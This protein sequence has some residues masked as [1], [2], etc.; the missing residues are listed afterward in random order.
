MTEAAFRETIKPLLRPNELEAETQ[1]HDRI[2]D[3]LNAPPHIRGQVQDVPALVQQLQRLKTKL[4]QSAPR[5]YLP[6]DADHAVRRLAELEASIKADMPSAEDMRRAPPGAVDRH[7]RWERAH[8][9]E[10]LEWKNIRLRLHATECQGGRF[11]HVKDVANIEMIRPTGFNRSLDDMGALVKHKD[12]HLPPGPITQAVL[13]TDI[14]RALLKQHAPEI[15]DALPLYTNEQRQA[16][17]DMLMAIVGAMAA[18]PK[19]PAK[20]VKKDKPAKKKRVYTAAQRQAA[21]E[22]ARRNFGHKPAEAAA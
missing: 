9:A 7:M 5:P 10:I 20:P 15:D 8:K 13:F 11:E 18:A 22:R 21:A 17:K 12:F 6:S 19:P 4:D 1:D 14:E 3:T 16:V 2:R